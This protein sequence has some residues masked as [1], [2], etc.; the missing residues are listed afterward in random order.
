VVL[1]VGRLIALLFGAATVYLSWL[2]TRELAPQA[3][4]W[5]IASG[6]VVALLPQFCFNSAHAGNDSTVTFAATAAFYVWIRGLYYP[7]FDRRLVGAGAMVGVAILA[8]LTALALIAG[9]VLLIVFRIFQ[10]APS[11][12]GWRNW[13]KRSLGMIAGATFSMVLVSGWW[14]ARNLLVYGEPTGMAAGLRFWSARFVKADFTLPRTAGDLCRYTLQSLWGRFG[15]ND[16]TL[17]Q[18]IYWLCNTAAFVL[19]SLTVVA[20]IGVL[21][22]SA[23]RKR[24]PFVACEVFLIFLAV[25]LAL[26]AGYLQFNKKIAYMPMARYFFIMVSPGA[27]L[28]T[29]GLYTFAATRPLRLAAFGILF[30]GLGLLNALALITVTRAGTATGGV[31][32]HISVEQMPSCW[33]AHV[34]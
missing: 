24:L 14:F 7:E 15:W 12:L 4:M 31:R 18:D 28:L 10:I 1:F 23:S 29:G 16:I 32:H 9:L 19:V 6:G 2:T 22:L 21:A 17:S 5:A 3:P 33:I 26:L 25:G 8:K 13:L 20:G 34:S 11:I 27:L 30:L